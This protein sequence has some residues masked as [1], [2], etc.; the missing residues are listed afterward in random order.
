MSEVRFTLSLE[1]AVSGLSIAPYFPFPRVI[2]NRQHVTITEAGVCQSVISFESDPRQA[3]ICCG[4][5][6]RA[7]VIHSTASL[8][9]AVGTC[10]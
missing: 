5:G 4:C 10:S 1:D 9:K 6:K 8:S 2:P 7:G 3:A